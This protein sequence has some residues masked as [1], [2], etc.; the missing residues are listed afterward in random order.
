M[1]RKIRICILSMFATI[2]I[3]L[4]LQAGQRE[5]YLECE[6]SNGDRFVLINKYDYSSMAKY[7]PHAASRINQFGFIVYFKP[8]NGGL[9]EE[10]VGNYGR[11]D[12]SIELEREKTCSRFF[13]LEGR[14]Q[15][16][17]YIF[18]EANG[19]TTR[20]SVPFPDYK[21]IDAL[22]EEAKNKAYIPPLYPTPYDIKNSENLRVEYSLTK[23]RSLVLL[24]IVDAIIAI[25]STDN[26]QTWSAPIITKDAKLFVIGKS[27][28]DQPAVAKPGKWSKGPG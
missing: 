21:L 9:L 19:K 1:S 6:L 24:N 18:N 2:V 26:G 22:D 28:L 8:K 3:S 20:E 10:S 23:A 15:S 12:V 25:E 14:A 17:A 16:S 27:I 5:D 13:V 7:I 11:F 4:D